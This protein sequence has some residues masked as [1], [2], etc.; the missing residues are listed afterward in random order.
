[1]TAEAAIK[2]AL[3]S[4]GVPF[5]RL[6]YRGHAA[7][8]ITYQLVISSERDF[9]DDENEAREYTFRLD[10]VSRCDFVPLLRRVW[11]ELKAGGFYGI[12]AEAEIYEKDTRLYHIPM[13][14]K[15]LESVAEAEE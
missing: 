1:M 10:L 9:Y 4:V 13:T 8:F 7:A 11:R 14:A 5:E 15:Y 6:T 2:A 3:E 12:S